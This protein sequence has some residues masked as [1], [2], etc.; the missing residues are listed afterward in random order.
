MKLLAPIALLALTISM[1]AGCGSSSDSATEAPPKGP[2]P[3]TQTAPPGT[4]GPQER[5]LSGGGEVEK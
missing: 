5:T 3:A 4:P 1:L 2:P